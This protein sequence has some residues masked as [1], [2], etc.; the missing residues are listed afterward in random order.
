[1]GPPTSGMPFVMSSQKMFSFM[2]ILGLKAIGFLLC[3]ASSG[4]RAG[5]GVQ[6][7]PVL[8]VL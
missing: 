2:M 6:R 3:Q 1:M 8:C 5:G 4:T 7:I